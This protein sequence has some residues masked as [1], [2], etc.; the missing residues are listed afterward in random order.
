LDN[1][2]LPSEGDTLELRSTYI[3]ARARGI[4]GLARIGRATFSIPG[5]TL[6]YRWRRYQSLEGYGLNLNHHDV[7]TGEGSWIPWCRKD[8]L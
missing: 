8:G 3:E 7:D 6:P 2:P 4:T 1:A 5:K